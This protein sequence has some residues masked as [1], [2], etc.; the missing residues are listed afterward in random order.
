[1][2]ALRPHR[3]WKG[4]WNEPGNLMNLQCCHL[5]TIELR[6]YCF[7]SLLFIFHICQMEMSCP[8][9]FTQIFWVI[10]EI[11]HILIF[12][13]NEYNLSNLILII[14]QGYSCIGTQV[15]QKNNLRHSQ[16]YMIRWGKRFFIWLGI[17]RFHPEE[18]R[19]DVKTKSTF[20]FF[21]FYFS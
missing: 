19:H 5:G 14:C 13:T 2:N 15:F 3:I 9:L 12:L 21:L 20:T 7:I 17:S 16:K 6:L 11:I 18:L 10:N 8:P 4:G 1:M